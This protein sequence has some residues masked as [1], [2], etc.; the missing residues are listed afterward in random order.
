MSNLNNDFWDFMVKEAELG[1]DEGG[2]IDSYLSG[3]SLEGSPFSSVQ[4]LTDSD[5]EKHALRLPVAAGTRV[6]FAGTL[7]S[8]LTYQN[9][10]EPGALGTVVSA[11]TATG[12]VT[13]HEGMVFVQWDGQPSFE[14]I[15]AAHLRLAES[16]SGKKEARRIRAGSLGDLTDFL[17]VAEDTLVHKST[18]DLW[19]F[20]KD[21]NDFVIERLFD[22]NGEP[23]KS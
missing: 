10:P 11:R 18:H 23:I 8:I 4:A 9:P 6:Q 7:G 13:D 2:S 15:H 21:G 19:S 1:A 22:S 17:K 16:T 5:Q 3:R 14:G 20:H 12:S